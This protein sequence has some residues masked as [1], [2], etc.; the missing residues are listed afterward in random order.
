M[1]IKTAL[2]VL[3]SLTV[4]GCGE[5][6][7]EKIGLSKRSPDEFSVVTRAPL[8]LPP[9]FNL[10]PPRPGAVR[11]Q[12]GTAQAQAQRTIFPLDGTTRMTDLRSNFQS[13]GFSASEASFLTQIGAHNTPDDIRARIDRETRRIVQADD[14]FTEKLIFWR[15]AGEPGVVVDPAAESRRLQENSALGTRGAGE[16]PTISRESKAPLEDVF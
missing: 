8:S 7:K 6:L 16:T 11:P 13:E 12:E 1:K 14:D 10:R 5:S 15:E 3:A 9:D 4:V 2:C